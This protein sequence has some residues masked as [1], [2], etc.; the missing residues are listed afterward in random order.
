MTS[1]TAPVS[2][3]GA[4]VRRCAVAAFAV[5]VAAVCPGL[6]ASG[7]T[8]AAGTRVAAARPASAG[9][10][11][12]AEEVPGTAALNTGGYAGVDSVSCAS[13]GDC[14]A[15]GFYQDSS[16]RQAFVVSEADGSW[17][18]AEEVPGTA[19]LNTGGDADIYSVSCA[20]A[21]NCAAGGLYTTGSFG[22]PAQAFV[23]SEQNGTW[24][25]A[26]TVAAAVNKGGFARI[27]SV[28]CAPAGNCS[29]G[30]D[31]RQASGT[32]QA[33]VISEKNGTWGSAQTVA[34]ALN[35]GAGNSPG[36]QISSVSCASPGNCGAGGTY[37]DAS[38]NIQAF[39]VGEKNGTWGTA[40]EVP[41]TAAVNTGGSASVQSV[42]CA[43]PGDCSAGGDYSDSSGS[44]A[45]VVS[46]KNG[47]WGSAKTI[48]AAFNKGGGGDILSVSC[49]SAGN[50]TA[51]GDYVDAAGM[52]GALAV[53]E[54]NGTWG[55][56]QQVI[57]GHIPAPAAL[58]YS[59]SCASPGNCSVG[60]S[61]GGTFYQHA[62]VVSEKNG[63]WGTGEEVPGTAA[64]NQ[65]KFARVESVSC[66]T[67]GNCSA[68]GYYK[69][70]SGNIQA[71][72]VGETSGAG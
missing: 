5:V 54:T 46:E 33:F 45:F 19:A 2:W 3:R 44:Q 62:F 29:A 69:D 51:A 24:G 16:G 20:S 23:V 11:G 58:I 71:F 9:T 47:T 67:A 53:S 40:E 25:S 43:S 59:V 35:Q 34:A 18:A 12:N 17:G 28:S 30:G 56:A 32:Y 63:T 38:G 48:A 13:P 68:G 21:G 37:T 41:G 60:G 55:A 4:V 64:L 61:A 31:Y 26:Q 65:G 42:S 66:A 14:G 6:L 49:A 27:L 70:A 57:T 15:G 7:A 8:A 36:A 50:C 52:T 22:G 1:E 39:V 10:W 72:V